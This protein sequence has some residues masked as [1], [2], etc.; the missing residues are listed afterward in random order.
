VQRGETR[1]ML[2]QTDIASTG[3]VEQEHVLTSFSVM[4]RGLLYSRHR[5]FFA[6][7]QV[8]QWNAYSVTEGHQ[9]LSDRR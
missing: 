3:R 2:E 1:A 5:S 4:A 9:D 6:E 7:F 8:I